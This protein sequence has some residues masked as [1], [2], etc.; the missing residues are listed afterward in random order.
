MSAEIHLERRKNVD[1]RGETPA[2]AFAP[3]VPTVTLINHRELRDKHT[4]HRLQRGSLDPKLA[5][6]SRYRCGEAVG[7]RTIVSLFCSSSLM[8]HMQ[9]MRVHHSE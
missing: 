2:S 4:G 3:R 1:L 8:V 5:P 7:H 9:A 6:S